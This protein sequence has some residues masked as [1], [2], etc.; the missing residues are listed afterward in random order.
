M[1]K[2]EHLVL[3]FS[4]ALDGKFPANRP[5]LDLIREFFCGLQLFGSFSVGLLD[6]SNVFIQ[7][8]SKLDYSRFFARRSYFIQKCWMRLLKWTPFF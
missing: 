1:K 4:L 3:P 5:N 8:S 2:I 6:G 7:F